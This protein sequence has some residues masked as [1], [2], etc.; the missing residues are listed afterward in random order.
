LTDHQKLKGFDN[1]HNASNSVCTH[2]LSNFARGLRATSYQKYN[3]KNFWDAKENEKQN[4]FPSLSKRLNYGRAI[5]QAASRRPV[6]AEAR[7]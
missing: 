3:N 4:T 6:I 7:V 5:G 2:F 1:Y